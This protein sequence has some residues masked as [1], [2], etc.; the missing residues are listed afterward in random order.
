MNRINI[1]PYR[2][3]WITMLPLKGIVTIKDQI[4]IDSLNKWYYR[5]GAKEV[6]VCAGNKDKALAKIEK[7]KGT[8]TKSYAAYIYTD[9]QFGMRNVKNPL[10][11]ILTTKQK[12][13]VIIFK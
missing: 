9:K 1:S 6:S 7:L 5:K 11:S 2:I 8:L 3:S 13:E 4:K 12:S 10:V